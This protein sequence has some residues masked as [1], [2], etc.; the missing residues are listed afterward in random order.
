MKIRILE[1]SGKHLGTISASE[2]PFQGEFVEVSGKLYKILKIVHSQQ[3]GY[4]LIIQV[5]DVF[6]E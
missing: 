3:P 2:R 5:T 6:S 1:K 4:V